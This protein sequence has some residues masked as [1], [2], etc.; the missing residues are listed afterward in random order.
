[1]WIDYRA[2]R[3]QISMERVLELIDYHPTSH[4]GHQL[5]GACPFH[6]PER[7]H[8]RCFSVELKKGLFRCFTCGA[9]GWVDENES[10]FRGNWACEIGEICCAI[11]VVGGSPLLRMEPHAMSRS[12]AS[13]QETPSYRSPARV[14][15]RFFERSRDLWK[16]KYKES[17]ATDQ[18]ISHRGAGLAS[19]AR[20]VAC[21]GGGP[22]KEDRGT[23]CPS[24][25]STSSSPPA[26]SR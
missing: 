20:S 3:S 8:P 15:A 25:N 14:L 16:A 10:F 12:E 4:R 21:Q 7:P 11:S 22:G 9:Q 18:G 19:V 24:C 1:M 5:R 23:A 17:A 13:D 6:S 26:P 2:V